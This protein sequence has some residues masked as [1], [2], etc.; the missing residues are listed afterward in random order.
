M[1]YHLMYMDDSWYLGILELNP[2]KQVEMK[3]KI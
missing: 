2:I 1:I 3:E